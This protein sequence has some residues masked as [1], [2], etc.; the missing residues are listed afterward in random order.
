MLCGPFIC[1]AALAL[2]GDT[3]FLS[4]WYQE[5]YQQKK[6]FERVSSFHCLESGQEEKLK[7]TDSGLVLVLVMRVNRN[8]IEDLSLMSN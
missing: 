6:K 8:I 1:M 3:G 2:L 7:K 4:I 5:S